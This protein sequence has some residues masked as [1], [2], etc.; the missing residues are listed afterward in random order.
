[1]LETDSLF[2]HL[3]MMHAF[4]RN[5]WGMMGSVRNVHVSFAL[6]PKQTFFTELIPPKRPIVAYQLFVIL[7]CLYLFA[8]LE[9]AINDMGV[10]KKFGRLHKAKPFPKRFMRNSF[11]NHGPSR[12][13]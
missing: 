2:G 10:L 5:I 11:L 12:F 3:A 1:M 4:P 9:L 13:S 8:T 7:G 6:I